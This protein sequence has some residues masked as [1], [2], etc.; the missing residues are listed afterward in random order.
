MGNN[1]FKIFFDKST[2]GMNRAEKEAYRQQLQEKLNVSEYVL[3]NWLSG[4]TIPNPLQ[5]VG[6]NQILGTKI[7]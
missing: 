5:Q 7:Y 2:I 6:I 4:V 1:K 3:R